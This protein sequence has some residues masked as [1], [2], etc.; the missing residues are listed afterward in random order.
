MQTLADIKVRQKAGKP[1]EFAIF[2]SRLECRDSEAPVSVELRAERRGGKSLFTPCTRRGS[3]LKKSHLAAENAVPGNVILFSPAFS[4]FD[5]FRNYKEKGEVYLFPASA[6]AATI[7]G[8][9]WGNNPN[10][11]TM[12]KKRQNEN[13]GSENNLQFAPGFFEEKTRCKQQPKNTPQDETTPT[14]VP[15]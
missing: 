14:S 15:R 12:V 1:A 10:M 4:S 5:L 2:A 11:Q 6:L 7:G 13:S 9:N 3:L 8:R